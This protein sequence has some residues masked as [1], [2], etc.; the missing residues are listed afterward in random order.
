MKN[1]FKKLLV[2]S[3][4]AL[5]IFLTACNSKSIAGTYLSNTED[6]YKIVIDKDNNVKWYEGSMVF[7]G[8]VEVDKDDLIFEIK[9]SGL[10]SDHVFYAEITDDGFAMG[11][12]SINGEVF[13]KE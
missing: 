5:S 7:E 9:G 8:T 2:I 4:V 1:I 10:I 11:K 12:S 13:T 6:K 3:I